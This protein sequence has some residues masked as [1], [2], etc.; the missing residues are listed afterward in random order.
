MASTRKRRWFQYRLRTLLASMVIIGPLS[1]WLGPSAAD[2]VRNWIEPDEP[3]GRPRECILTPE[4]LREINE[5]WERIWSL[6]MPDDET[7]FRTHG[8]VI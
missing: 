6:D 7:P 3:V 8:G 1:I 5:E 2:A 4:D